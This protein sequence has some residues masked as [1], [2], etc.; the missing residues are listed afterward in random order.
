MTNS[1]LPKNFALK[2]KLNIYS[3]KNIRNL[4]ETKVI[5]FVSNDDSDGTKYKIIPFISED[6]N[7]YE[8]EDNNINIKVEDIKFDNDNPTIKIITEKNK[9][10][11]IFDKNS[12]FMDTGKVKSMIK[13]QKIPDCS[14]NQQNQIVSL[15]IDKIEACEFNL[16]S[17]EGIIISK[18]NLSIDL[19]E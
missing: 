14:N 15:N 6:I 4:D 1:P 2:L 19:V 9:C 10:S 17:E 8:M 11:L 7:S 16:N 5:S 18:D 13:E 12:D 3:S